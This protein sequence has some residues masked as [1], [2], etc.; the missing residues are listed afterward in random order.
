[1]NEIFKDIPGYEGLYQVSNL[2][3]VKS[4]NYKGTRK[5]KILIP[6][7]DNEESYLRINLYKNGS[8][9]TKCVHC[10]VAE[11]F[12]V[13]PDN[14]P[15]VNH[16]DENK[17]NNSIDNLEYC[18]RNYNIRYSKAKRVGCFKDGI[19]L[20]V[21]DAMIDVMNDGHYNG[22]VSSCCNGKN[23]KHHGLIWKFLQ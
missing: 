19:L 18:S 12:L 15:E 20:K 13:N 1:M 23:K 14:L 17:Q 8:R 11:T 4:L 6:F 5:E 2:G 9:K 3:N 10:L 21:Y 16:K 7:K 22:A